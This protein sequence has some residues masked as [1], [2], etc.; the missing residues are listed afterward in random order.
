MGVVL[1]GGSSRIPL[2]ERLISEQTRLR[3]FA[4]PDR[5][6]VVAAGA[7]RWETSGRNRPE[8]VGDG[9]AEAPRTFAGEFSCRLAI[10]RGDRWRNRQTK[11]V[12]GAGELIIR[13]LSLTQIRWS[14]RAEARRRTDG[15]TVVSP[16]PLRTKL[17]DLPALQLW[18]L[19]AGQDGSA[20]KVPAS[21]RFDRGQRE[22]GSRNRDRRAR[23]RG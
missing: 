20:C 9:V 1:T 5:K 17:A 2:V 15:R 13:E 7:A 19:T 22:T 23:G 14:A 3:V 11:L 16:A 6:G 21:L 8:L 18:T 10:R 4:Q 12:I